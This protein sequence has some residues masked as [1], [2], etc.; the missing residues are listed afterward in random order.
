MQQN[1]LASIRSLFRYYKSLGDKAIAQLD[2]QQLRQPPDAHSNSVA[3]IVKHMAGNMLSRWTDFLTTDGEKPWRNR[4]DEFVDSITNKGALLAYWEQGWSC[5]FQ[6]IDGLTAKDL[7]RIV[8]IR[9]EGH[10]ALE[11][12]NRQL[13]HYAY[14][15]GQ[16]VFLAKSIKGESWQSLTIPKGAS[17]SFNSEKF[18]QE[19]ARKHFT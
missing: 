19:K 4:E 5:L 14:H 9:N 11:A 15:I 10:T 8:Y 17:A 2:D 16:I 7:E 12:I 13:A 18:S 1:F 6:A 3:I